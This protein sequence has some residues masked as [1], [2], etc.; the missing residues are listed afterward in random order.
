MSHADNINIDARI[1]ELKNKLGS[2]VC[3]LGHH[4]QGDGVAAHCD[5]MGDSLELAR[6]IADIDAEHIVF[7]GVYFM[8]ETAAL[9]AAP[10]QK[11]YLPEPDADCMMSLMASEKLARSVLEELNQSGRKVIPLAYVNTMLELKNVV[12]EYG[13]AVCTSANAQKMLEWALTQGDSV[14]F[15]PDKNLGRNV[16]KKLGIPDEEQYILKLTGRGLAP[17]QEDKLS[18]KLLLWPGSCAVHAKLSPKLVEESHKNKKCLVLAHPECKPEVIEK[19]DG[20]GSTSFL[21]KETERIARE[22]PGSEVVIGTEENLVERLANKY[23]N[24]LKI[25]P[26]GRAVCPHMEKV[27]PEKLLKTLEQV[28]EHRGAYLQVDRQ[29]AENARLSIT[30]MLDVCKK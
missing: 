25:R 29:K 1:S 18:A 26:L 24:K 16:A 11:V 27:T 15:L 9:L 20:A 12:G 3:I 10:N 28:E 17:G 2:S 21:I 30:R 23:A 14:L 4:Y 22:S 7:C 13:G 5:I 19:C 6:K 8:G